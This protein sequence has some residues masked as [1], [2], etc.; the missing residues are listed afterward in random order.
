MKFLITKQQLNLLIETKV[1]KSQR[2]EIYR[3]NNIVV[4]IPLTHSALQKYA[5]GC[6][7]CINND[8]SEWEDYHQ[9]KS[10]III[11]RNKIEDRIGITKNTTAEEIFQINK[12]INGALSFDKL[13]DTLSYDFESEFATKKYFSILTKNIN[14]F[15]LNKLYFSS[16]YGLY[17]MEDNHL[18]I[19][20]YE[21]TDVPNVSLNISN[22]IYDVLETQN[23]TV[24]F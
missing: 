24:D 16:E 10:C 1:P 18:S 8:K 20:G 12:W 21:L 2:V 6:S 11:Q 7:W 22:K 14:N 17:D 3:D 15:S 9:G 13:K 23:T 19:F 4:I 5:T